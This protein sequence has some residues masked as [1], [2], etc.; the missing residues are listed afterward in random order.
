MSIP[1]PIK[2]GRVVWLQYITLSGHWTIAHAFQGRVSDTVCGK[3]Y[4]RE[5]PWDARSPKRTKRCVECVRVVAKK[6]KKVK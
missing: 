6:T 2:V 3:Q 4:V 5:W 1:S